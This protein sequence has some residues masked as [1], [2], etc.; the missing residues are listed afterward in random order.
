MMDSD[1]GEENIVVADANSVQSEQLQKKNKRTRRK[2]RRKNEKAEKGNDNLSL[3]FDGSLKS[4]D[5]Q[6]HSSSD[7]ISIPLP[8]FD[9]NSA[10]VTKLRNLEVKNKIYP[11][12]PS[13][14][15][16]Q[17]RFF[18]IKATTE[19]DIH[20]VPRRSPVHKVRPLDLQSAGEP[21]AEPGFCRYE[22]ES[23]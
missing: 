10:L 7:S 19:D 13:S 18:V 23:Q 6:T 22:V 12:T 11:S 3:N 9:D 2:R 14:S 5:S 8:S 17:A 16:S 21:Q 1:D 15:V 20:K 4:L